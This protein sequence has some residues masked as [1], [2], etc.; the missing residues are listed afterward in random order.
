MI[1]TVKRL[2]PVGALHAH[3]RGARAPGKEEL[4]VLLRELPEERRRRGRDTVFWGQ[5]RNVVVGARLETLDIKYM[6][7]EDRAQYALCTEEPAE[8]PATIKMSFGQST[9]AVTTSAV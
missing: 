9:G 5:F 4:N 1:A 7:A 8:K 2:Q 3:G 6:R